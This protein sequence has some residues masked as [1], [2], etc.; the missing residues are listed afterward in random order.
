MKNPVDKIASP[1][2]AKLQLLN[3]IKDVN[4]SFYNEFVREFL[5]DRLTFVGLE[6]EL[7]NALHSVSGI[8]VSRD[9]DKIFISYKN[10]MEKFDS[11]EDALKFAVGLLYVG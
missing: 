8:T 10:T 1:L 11:Y 2:D 9:E 7:V 3:H 4:P 5:T 6:K